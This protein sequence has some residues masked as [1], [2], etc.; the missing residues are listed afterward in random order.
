MFAEY[1]E[2]LEIMRCHLARSPGTTKM[3]QSDVDQSQQWSLSNGSQAAWQHGKMISGPSPSVLR[4]NYSKNSRHAKVEPVRN[5]LKQLSHTLL[6]L[7]LSWKIKAG[8]WDFS[9][10]MGTFSEEGTTGDPSLSRRA[11]GPTGCSTKRSLILQRRCS[12]AKRRRA[13]KRLRPGG[14]GKL[15]ALARTPETPP[16]DPSLDRRLKST[17]ADQSESRIHPRDGTGREGLVR[18]TNL[19]W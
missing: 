3:A 4:V 1:S 17:P 5:F 8:G 7:F 6:W 18:I 2:S 14:V 9:A 10:G 15:D 16:V 13:C 11:S 19:G 12:T